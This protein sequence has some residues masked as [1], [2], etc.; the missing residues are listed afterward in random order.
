[1]K[2]RR[3]RRATLSLFY[4]LAL[5]CCRIVVFFFLHVLCSFPISSSSFLCTSYA[6]FLYRRLLFSARPM[7]LSYIVVFFFVHVLCSF[8]ISSSS[9]LCTSYAPFLYR[10][11][12]FSARPMLLSYIIMLYSFSC[13]VVS[14]FQY[15]QSI[16]I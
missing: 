14:L 11:L 4:C 2:A 9:F 6:P 1:M 15:S 13:V 3:A 16:L 5:F 7:L 8:P 12:L 10:R